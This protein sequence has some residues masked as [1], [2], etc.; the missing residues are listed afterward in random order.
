MKNPPRPKVYMQGNDLKAREWAR[1][2]P[3]APQHFTTVPHIAQ[4]L[5]GSRRGDVIIYR[6]QNNPQRLLS[7]VIVTMLL[8]FQILKSRVFGIAIV[9][10]CHNVNEDTLPWHK[11]LERLRRAMLQRFAHHVLLLDSAFL[12]Y[13][14]RR[15]ARVISFGRKPKG[16]ISAESLARITEFS[17]DRHM[18]ILIAGQ[19]G[20][21]Y[22]SFE[23]IPEL[24]GRL[25][26]VGR[27]VGFVAAGIAPDR[28]FHANVEADILRV[29]ERNIDET[30]IAHLVSFVY[31]E[32]GD[33]SMPFT[34]YA[35]AS[36]KIPVL[37]DS[38]NILADIVTREG[39]GITVEALERGVPVPDPEMY[40]TFLTRHRWDSLAETLRSLGLLK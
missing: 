37:T 36:A 29:D 31:R 9:W 1:H 17:R 28:R 23:R 24:H 14:A 10:I 16:T 38:G 33:I 21:K 19:D 25:S 22:Q 4:M 34:V 40:E 6:Y 18:V 15:D 26:G 7:A 39:I 30:A 13:I 35:A 2:F 8:G 12:P 11:P 3:C 27:R 5:V 20:L 32:N